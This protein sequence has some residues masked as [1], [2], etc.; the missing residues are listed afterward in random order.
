MAESGYTPERPDPRDC[1]ILI[2]TSRCL[3]T[4]RREPWVSGQSGG[5]QR[6]RCW[7]LATSG[8]TAPAPRLPLFRGARRWRA[9]VEKA[10]VLH[11]VGG[12]E[13]LTAKRL[14]LPT[15][16]AIQLAL[17]SEPSKGSVEQAGGS[18]A[19]NPKTNPFPRRNTEGR[20]P[21]APASPIHHT[22]PP[23]GGVRTAR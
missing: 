22:P 21:A 19:V 15:S 1:V 3:P 8:A 20:S 2:P 6:W 23:P 13:D 17:G 5:S 14:A 12:T 11:L 10:P 4:R 16:Q 9:H 7:A 18:E